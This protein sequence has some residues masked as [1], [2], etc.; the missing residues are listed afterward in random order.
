MPFQ[1]LSWEKSHVVKPES[2]D[3]LDLGTELLAVLV[4]SEYAQIADANQK[5]AEVVSSVQSFFATSDVGVVFPDQGSQHCFYRSSAKIDDTGNQ[6][7]F[8]QKPC[9]LQPLKPT[10]T[11]IDFAKSIAHKLAR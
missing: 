11:I 10:L 8:E 2:S 6:V 5:L 9:F 7:I 4:F 1:L 3:K